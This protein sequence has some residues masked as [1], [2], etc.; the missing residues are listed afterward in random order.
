MVRHGNNKRRRIEITPKDS[1]L[2]SDDA[3]PAQA[4]C[5]TSPSES[6][7]NINVSMNYYVYHRPIRVPR[8]GEEMGS[9]LFLIILFNLALAHHL[10]ATAM[11]AVR[12]PSPSHSKGLANAIDKSLMLYQLV[13]EY[14]SK[15]QRR[16]E[17][18]T[19]EQSLSSM[20][21]KTNNY[22]SIWFRMILHNNLGQIYNWTEKP[23][24]ETECLN[25]L[26]STVLL[27]TDQCIQHGQVSMPKSFQRDM[28]GFLSNTAA[29]TLHEQCAGMA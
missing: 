3:V 21:N 7:S 5:D 17:E 13:V 19:Y 11:S 25:D 15:L 24:K 14:W 9:V 20:G 26:L 8:Q 23:T 29:L 2:D 12:K 18:N 10:K 27:A 16:M 6:E 22:S 28:E 1:A 4:H